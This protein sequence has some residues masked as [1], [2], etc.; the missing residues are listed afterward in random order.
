MLRTNRKMHA[1]FPLLQIRRLKSG[2][3]SKILPITVCWLS[4]GWCAL[5]G[6]VKMRLP[7][8]SKD[9]FYKEREGNSA[10]LEHVYKRI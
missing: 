4:L 3:A 8:L 6:V 7:V 9:E 5:F 1:H 10:K 2:K